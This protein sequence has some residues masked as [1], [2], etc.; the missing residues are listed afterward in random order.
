MRIALML[1]TLAA[2]KADLPKL[3][4]AHGVLDGKCAGAFADTLVDRFPST[5][6]APA[7]LGAPD[8]MSVTLTK[9]QFFTVA[10]TG[11]GAI[12]DASGPDVKINA[13][14]PSGAMATV[15]VADTDMAFKY[16]GDLTPT[17]NQIDIA[18]AFVPAAPYLRIT[19]VT[20]SVQIESIV[21]IHDMCKQ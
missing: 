4:D 17:N 13:M 15:R 18:V 19:G 20:G 9:D 11:L 2:C 6:D 7:A 12:S 10:F 3:T 21:A 14:V 8:T 5:L 16:A 1:A